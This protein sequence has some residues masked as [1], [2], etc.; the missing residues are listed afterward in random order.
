[1]G[2]PFA[3]TPFGQIVRVA[4]SANVIKPIEP[5]RIADW[6]HVINEGSDEVYLYMTNDDAQAH[7]SYL[8]IHVGVD[9]GLTLPPTS[10]WQIVGHTFHPN[11]T[12]FWLKTPQAGEVVLLWF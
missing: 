3:Q 11:Y 5:P 7:Q 10:Y 8:R 1:M 9:R 6:V 4:L 2:T 12:A